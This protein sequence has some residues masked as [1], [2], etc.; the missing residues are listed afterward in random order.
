M[1]SRSG[2]HF[3]GYTITRIASRCE[4]CVCEEKCATCHG[5]CYHLYKCDPLCYDYVNGHLC[6]HL[7]RIH[8]LQS[9]KNDCEEAMDTI[10]AADDITAANDYEVIYSNEEE[11]KVKKDP[12]HLPSKSVITSKQSK[13]DWTYG[14]YNAGDSINLQQLSLLTALPNNLLQH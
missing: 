3:P 14:L 8:T 6:K 7:H 12:Y 11:E 10:S 2:N 5:L 9:D 4:D 13:V 1:P